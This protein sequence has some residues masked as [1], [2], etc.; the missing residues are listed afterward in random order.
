MS[1]KPED[2]IVAHFYGRDSRTIA[3]ILTTAHK[4]CD[5]PH[6]LDL[7][8]FEQLLQPLITEL[9]SSDVEAPVHIGIDYFLE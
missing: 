4:D 9:F 3:L 5:K 7:I 1:R 2:I 8:G 6:Q